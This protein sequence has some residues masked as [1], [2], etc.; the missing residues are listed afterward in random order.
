MIRPDTK[1]A[2]IFDRKGFTFVE[3]IV[4]MVIIAILGAVMVVKNPFQAM[5]IY[6]A[7]RKVAADIRYAQQLAKATQTRCGLLFIGSTGYAVFTNNN[8]AT[9]ARSAGDPCA[10][11]GAGNFVVNFSTSQCSSYNGVTISQALPSSIV[12]FNSLGTPYGG[13]D[14]LLVSSVITLSLGGTTSRSITIEAGTGRVSY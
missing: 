3:T 5:K 13:D 10:D 14:N 9:R 8:T 6:S 1:A 11:D 2:M 4:V 7:T 12:K